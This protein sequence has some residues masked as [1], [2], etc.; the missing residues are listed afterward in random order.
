[1]RNDASSEL[2]GR[3]SAGA[4]DSAWPEFLDRYSPLIKHVIRR[5]ETDPELAAECYAQVCAALSDDG[6]R[7]LRGFRPDGPARFRTWLMAVVSN[8]CVDWRRTRQGRFR[9]PQSVAHLPELDQQVFRL[10]YVDGLSRAQCVEVLTPRFP[11][12]TDA[13]VAEINGRLFALLTPQQRWQLAARP[14]AAPSAA[15]GSSQDDD[16]AAF[17]AVDPQAS[18][19]ELAGQLQEQQQLRE[20]LAQLPAQQR[21]LLRLRYE[22]E[23]TLAEVARLTR[24]PDPFRA[25]RRIH[26]ALEALAELM[27]ARRFPYD[28]K[29]P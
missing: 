3:L 29:P 10:I 22:Q 2:I 14:R 13:T 8:L 26:E 16:R 15:R 5:H 9:L 27:N 7:R 17:E 23:L 1:M 24:Q 21:L 28:R 6:F 20:A 11:G 12:L 4:V 25:N 18:P 19:D